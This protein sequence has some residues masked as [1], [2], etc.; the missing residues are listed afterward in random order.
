V[1]KEERY[2]F[3][4]YPLEVFSFSLLSFMR[5]R[6]KVKVVHFTLVYLFLIASI[7]Y[8]SSCY[9]MRDKKEKRRYGTLVFQ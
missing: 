8:L 4:Y 5:N 9:L 2:C 7:F 6:G 1:E 3:S